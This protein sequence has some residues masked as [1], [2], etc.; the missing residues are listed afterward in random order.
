MVG[1]VRAYKRQVQVKRII[2]IEGWN[3]YEVRIRTFHEEE[4][5]KSSGG[6][7]R[8]QEVR[9]WSSVVKCGAMNANKT[10]KGAKVIQAQRGYKNKTNSLNVYSNAALIEDGVETKKKTIERM[11]WKTII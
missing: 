11:G 9:S 5:H 4:V 2:A 10:D 1:V 8:N 6:V 3:Q 7:N